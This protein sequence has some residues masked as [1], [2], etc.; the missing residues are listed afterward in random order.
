MDNID[1]LDYCLSIIDSNNNIEKIKLAYL[2]ENNNNLLH[3]AILENSENSVKYLVD[4]YPYFLEQYNSDFVSPMFLSASLCKI[5]MLNILVKQSINKSINKNIN[6]SVLGVYPFINIPNLLNKVVSVR[7]LE[8]INFC[9]DLGFCAN[10]RD[11]DFDSPLG[12]AMKISD[13]KLRLAIVNLLCINSVDIKQVNKH[14]EAPLDIA[15][16]SSDVELVACLKNQGCGQVLCGANSVGG[17]GNL[18][19]RISWSDFKLRLSSFYKKVISAL[20]EE[21]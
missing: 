4:K 9:M 15:L 11:A 5:K 2:D 8:L 1:I 20:S 17:S 18:I 16:S 7:N 10:W 14:G 6:D 21:Y 3:F 13:K 12:N 19:T